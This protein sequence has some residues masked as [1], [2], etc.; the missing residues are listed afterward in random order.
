MIRGYRAAGPGNRQK[1]PFLAL[2]TLVPYGY[3]LVAIFKGR[4]CVSNGCPMVDTLG[5]RGLK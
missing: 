5:V 1:P 4:R 2:T 3:L